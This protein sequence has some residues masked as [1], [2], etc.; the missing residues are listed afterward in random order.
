MAGIFSGRLLVR[1]AAENLRRSVHRTGITVAALSVAVAMMTGL[2]IMIF[3]FRTSVNDWVQRGVVADLFIAPASNETIGSGAFI[4]PETVSWLRSQ[5]G[6]ESVDTSRE[7][8]VTIGSENALLSVIEGAYHDNMQ[9]VGGNAAAKMARVF[10]GET[11]AVS[12]SFAR[13]MRVRDGSR[14]TLA[15]PV[16]QRD[17]EVGGVYSDYTRDQGVIFM[18]RPLFDRFWNDSRV[19]N[20]AVYLKP[21]VPWEPVAE[22]LRGKFSQ[23]GE[24]LVFSNRTLRERIFTIFDQTFTVTYVLRTIAVVVALV[25]IFLSV[26]TLVTERV[27]EISALRAIGASPAQIQGLVMIESAMIGWLASVLGIGA[28]TLLALVLTWV[29]NPAFFGWSIAVHFPWWALAAVPLWIVPAAVL[30][31]W[32]PAWGASRLKIAQAL[33]GE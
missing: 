8:A 6:V 19:Q 21:G 10:A 13:R 29:V 1:L 31:A 20:L 9:F 2:T 3:S 24:L 22:A 16:G 33:R 25:G 30:A 17:F 28:G 4:L 32:Y 27:R 14:I 26:T 23:A 5:P 18:A 15:T 12:E 11:V 7:L